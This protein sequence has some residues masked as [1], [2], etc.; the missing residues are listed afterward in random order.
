MVFDLHAHSHYSDGILSPQALMSRAKLHGV[1]TIAL[2]DHDTVAGCT[3]AASAAA[4]CGMRFIPGIEFSTQWGKQGVHVVG[5]GVD[6]TSPILLEAVAAQQHARV[7]RNLAIALKLERQGVVEPLARAQKI[8]GV[9][10]IGR[11]HFAQVLVN[12]GRVKDIATAFKKFLGAGKSCDVRYSWPEISDI[13]QVIAAVGGVSVLAHPA[14]YNLTRTKMRALIAAFADCGGRAL[15][16]INGRQEA[17]L[18]TELVK[19]AAQHDLY[20]SCGSDFHKP[21]CPWQ[22]LGNFASLP[23]NARPVWS[24]FDA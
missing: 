15:E 16:V 11:P 2:T 8:A 1:E 5:L 14:K 17:S 22:E 6:C 13:I 18:T 20:S 12:D 21:D 7:E 23:D 9:A 3:E 24:L 19:F 4:E 10:L